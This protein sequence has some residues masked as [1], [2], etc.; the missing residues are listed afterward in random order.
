MSN[1]FTPSITELKLNIYEHFCTVAKL[2][3]SG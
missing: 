3:F 1:G 2:S